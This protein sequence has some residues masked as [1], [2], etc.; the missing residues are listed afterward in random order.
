VT[1]TKLDYLSLKTFLEEIALQQGSPFDLA[2]A[3]REARIAINSARKILSGLDAVFLV[4]IIRKDGDTHGKM[5]FLEDQGLATFLLQERGN[6]YAPKH[7]R[8]ADWTRLLFQQVLAQIKYRS[9]LHSDLF[10]FRTRGGA[11]MDLCVRLENK[12]IGYSV[13]TGSQASPSQIASATRFHKTFPE[14]R[15]LL[16]HQGVSFRKIDAEV[17][18]VPFGTVL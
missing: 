17:Y 18:E 16:L 15:V 2:A 7:L 8:L 13:G 10:S 5:V 11:I 12:V 9:D 3:A 6:S 14:A 1:Q 4:R